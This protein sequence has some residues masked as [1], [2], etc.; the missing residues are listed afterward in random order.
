MSAED[1]PAESSVAVKWRPWQPL[2]FRGVARFAEG[3]LWRIW[4]MELVV[5]VAVAV[6]LVW[7]LQKCYAPVIVQAVQQMPDGAVIKDG[8]LSGVPETR[9]SETKLIAIAVTSDEETEIGQAADMQIQFRWGGIRVGSAFWPDWGL[10]FDYGAGKAEVS[11]ASLEPLWGAWRPVIF[12]GCGVGMMVE[13]AVTWALLATLYSA[14]A[15]VAAWF[16]DRKL[17][18]G[19][20]WK[21]SAAALMPGALLLVAGLALYG[22]EAVDLIGLSCFFAAHFVVGWI[23]VGGAIFFLERATAPPAKNPFTTGA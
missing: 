11:R 12:A 22:T 1:S 21:L 9:L 18:W 5:A 8:H 4:L 7:F 17:S 10:K 13:L 3:E 23:Y 2:T 14:P 6:G 15:K 20:A 19:G 16:G